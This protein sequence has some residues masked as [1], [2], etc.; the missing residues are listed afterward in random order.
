MY[1]VG[2]RSNS[3]GWLGGPLIIPC[4]LCNQ[5]RIGK[6]ATATS[7]R[8]SGRACT[9]PPRFVSGRLATMAGAICGAVRMP[10]AAGWLV[11]GVV[12]AGVSPRS[13][14]GLLDLGAL[15]LAG[16]LMMAVE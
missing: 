7:S 12:A 2:S 1:G 13:A 5:S 11:A 6:A 3:P 9:Q 4:G 14:K 16:G 8:I 15:R 10:V